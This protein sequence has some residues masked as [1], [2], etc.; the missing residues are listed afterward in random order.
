MKSNS[1]IIFQPVEQSIYTQKKLHGVPLTKDP[2]VDK[3][4]RLVML[5]NIRDRDRNSILY[6]FCFAGKILKSCN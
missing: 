1:F 3:Y 4:T 6:S 2:D 5:I